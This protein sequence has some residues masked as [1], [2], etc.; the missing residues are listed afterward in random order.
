MY[1]K[2][3]YLKKIDDCITKCLHYPENGSVTIRALGKQDASRLPQFHGIID[4]VSVLGLE[5]KPIWNRSETGLVITTN[6]VK[7][8]K[9]VVFKIKLR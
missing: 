7:S 9:P 5:E 3:E 8:D 6:T 1:N 2:E 4:D